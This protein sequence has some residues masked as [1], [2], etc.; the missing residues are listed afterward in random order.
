MSSFYP[1]FNVA[2][3]SWE[4]WGLPEDGPAGG[5]TGALPGAGTL[6]SA[7]EGPGAGGGERGGG[8]G[9]GEEAGTPHPLTRLVRTGEAAPLV[10][11]WAQLQWGPADPQTFPAEPHQRPH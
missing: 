1:R 10:S 3:S 9:E 11:I 4:L 7:W 8:Q 5:Q 6:P 2:V